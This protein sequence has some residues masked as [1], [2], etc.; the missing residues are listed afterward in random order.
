MESLIT[1]LLLYPKSSHMVQETT[2]MHREGSLP[3][4]AVDEA[5]RI[6]KEDPIKIIKHYMSIESCDTKM[7]KI[8]GM[9]QGLV[10]LN[11][12]SEQIMHEL[13]IARGHPTHD[14]YLEYLG[15]ILV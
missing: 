2:R 15:S 8:L 4:Y 5:C 3:Q 6:T 13:Q 10:N 7:F 9:N 14:C 11:K 1:D 12:S